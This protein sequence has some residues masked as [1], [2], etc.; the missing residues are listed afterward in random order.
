MDQ[1]RVSLP[2]L[3]EVPREAWQKL[4]QK[5]IF[6]GHQ[7]VGDNIL[8][9]IKALKEENQQI[10][11]NIV[12]AMDPKAVNTSGIIHFWVG[13][14]GNVNSKMDAF[15][16][17]MDKGRSSGPDIA[18]F[19]FC[20]VD[21]TPGTDAFKVFE[22]YKA[23]MARLEKTYPNTTF[24]HVTVPLTC[25]PAGMEGWI[26]RAKN[27]IKQV[28]GRPV[29]DL[30]D[31]SKRHEFNELM[32]KEYEGKAPF[33]DLARIE[34]TSPDGKRASYSKKGSIY[35]CLVPE[36]TYDGGHLNDLGSKLL[37]GQLLIF[38]VNLSGK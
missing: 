15:G 9:G 25:M 32:R 6:F 37:A 19:K 36:Y 17:Y 21:F 1:T 5:R 10:N 24:V 35:D 4:A 7:S 30:R 27:L 14:N 38:L 28:I 22:E 2:S 23:A 33:F 8:K 20:F 3:K 34:S 29:F 18:F 11:I 26:R 12:Q 13:E 16:S 31:N